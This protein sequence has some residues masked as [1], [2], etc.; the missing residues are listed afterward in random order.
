MTRVEGGGGGGKGADDKDDLD[1]ADADD[2]NA[3]GTPK[4][5][6]QKAVDTAYAKLRETEAR[7]KEKDKEIATLKRT[8]MTA[9]EAAEARAT[10]AEAKV[11]EYEKKE[12]R[13]ETEK[14]I[15]RI[16][17]ALKFKNPE[18]SRRFV[19]MDATDDKAIRAALRETLDD[20]PDLAGDGTP[21]PPVNEGDD[22]AGSASRRMNEKI[23][24]MAGR[25]AA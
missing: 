24:G 5:A 16:A 10:D 22:T 17:K 14:D 11:V 6:A 13:A 12:A 3:D 1:D 18:A 23:R 20:F 7:E 2:K 21:P 25:G 4:T 9:A 19:P 8:G 15:T